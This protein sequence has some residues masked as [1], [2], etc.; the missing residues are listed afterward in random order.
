MLCG[1]WIKKR[2][3]GKYKVRQSKSFDRKDGLIMD[4]MNCKKCGNLFTS[5]GSPLC[6]QCTKELDQ[7]FLEVKQFIYD[8][9]TKNMNQVAEEMEV[10]IRQIKQWIREEK[11]Q[12][13][14][15]SGVTF[16]CE[17]CGAQIMTGRFCKSCKSRMTDTL[18]GLYVEK[19]TDA[20][21]KR[22]AGGKMH[23]LGN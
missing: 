11:L 10:P 6:P 1:L 15:S 13:A 21:G 5:T 23:F 16:S 8:N 3:F 18:T 7:K 2:I 19:K 12:F 4:F 22:T 14:E 17:K 9:P 20:N